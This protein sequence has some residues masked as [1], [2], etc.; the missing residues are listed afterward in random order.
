MGPLSKIIMPPPEANKAIEKHYDNIKYL[1]DNGHWRNAT[2]TISIPGVHTYTNPLQLEQVKQTE[3]N[4]PVAEL[5]AWV[6]DVTARSAEARKA[7]AAAAASFKAKEAQLEGEKEAELRRWKRRRVG[8]DPEDP[9]AG[10]VPVAA[11]ASRG[12]FSLAGGVA[13]AAA[14]AHATG[15]F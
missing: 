4:M 7:D 1:I 11:P 5:S 13:A 3:A 8:A 6:E 9:V 2:A 12:G 10:P 14:A 15:M